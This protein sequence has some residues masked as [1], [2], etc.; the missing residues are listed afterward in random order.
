MPSYQILDST[1]GVDALIAAS[2]EQPQLVLKH[3]TTCPVSSLVK[4]RID[5]A[6]SADT[7]TI[8]THYLD[9]LRYRNVSNYVSEALGVRHESP[10]IILIDK[11]EVIHHASHLA[12]D[13]A[14]LLVG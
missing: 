8:S 14:A 10:Q 2:H 13:P 5:R 9:L 3:S 11:G 7:F 1:E 12:I 6:I 4:A